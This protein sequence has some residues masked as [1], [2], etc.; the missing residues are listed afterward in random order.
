MF[1]SHKSALAKGPTELVCIK[2]RNGMGRGVNE[3]FQHPT[4]NIQKSSKLQ[5]PSSREAP[6][7]GISESS[8]FETRSS[9]QDRN[10]T[11]EWADQTAGDRFVTERRETTVKFRT[12]FKSKV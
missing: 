12:K 5:A 6:R 7:G 3:K 11:F 4:S 10:S 8:K 2:R 9:K 1:F